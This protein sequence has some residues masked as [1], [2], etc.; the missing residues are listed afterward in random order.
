MRVIAIVILT[1]S[2]FTF[3]VTS[4]A[5]SGTWSAYISTVVD[6]CPNPWST[7]NPCTRMYAIGWGY[8]TRKEAIDAVL[9]ECRKEGGGKYCEIDPH[10]EADRKD[11]VSISTGFGLGNLRAYMGGFGDTEREARNESL[12]EECIKRGF[13]KCRHVTS[14]CYSR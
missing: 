9:G 13:H 12:H 1:I 14:K 2:I 3:P 4:Y 10:G 11:C 5:G 8:K 6:D 7:E